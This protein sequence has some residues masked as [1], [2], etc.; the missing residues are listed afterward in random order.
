MPLLPAIL[1]LP[2]L[3]AFDSRAPAPQPPAAPA[4]A[5]PAAGEPAADPAAL[6]ARAVSLQQSGEL[7][8]AVA[9]Y[10]QALALGVDSPAVRSNLGAA[11][12]G[13]GRYEQAIEQYRRALAAEPGNVP[14]RRNL[15]LAFYKTGRMGEAAVEAE[16][17]ASAQPE[18]EAAT[19]L[20]ADCLYRLGRSSRVIELLQPIAAR[21]PDRAVSYLL[22][23]ALIGEGRMKEAQAAIDRV[24]RDDSPE[25]H[26]FLAMMYMRDQDCDKA[27]PE[28]RK[29]R[30]GNPKLPL[31]HFLDGQ[32]LM[33]EKRGDWPGAMEA[34]RAELAIDPN[35]FEANLY[36]G[37]LLREGARHEEALP[38][39][40]RALRLRPDALAA[41]FSLGAV[42]VALGRTQEALPLLEAVAAAAPDHLQTHMQLAVVY[43][44]LGRTADS[45][46][47]RER[48]GQLQS[49]GESRF[50]KGVSDALGRLL[51]KTPAP[52]AGRQ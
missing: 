37:D 11:Y 19:V 4:P 10:E 13:L 50:F 25:A 34:F 23:M 43:H 1:L 39:L 47:E 17:V 32:C 44:R 2:R 42:Y 24:L 3:L 40:E 28:I 41:K 46:R 20:L 30:D 51:G 5:V 52:E 7:A 31:V 8:G 33:D 36:L 49:E 14:I 48:V 29:A 45:A 18:N 38:Y 21:S 16:A 22:G 6:V 12:A 27:L 35:H 26:V 9:A 15:A